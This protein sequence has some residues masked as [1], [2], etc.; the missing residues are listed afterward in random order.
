MSVRVTIKNQGMLDL[1][2]RLADLHGMSIHLGWQGQEGGAIHP[3]ASVP[4]AQ[5]G[6]FNEF[7][8]INAPAR[9]ALRTS[10]VDNADKFA[11]LYA[12]EYGKVIAGKKSAVEASS[13]IGKEMAKTVRKRI[14]QANAWAVPNAPA[15]VE[16][17]G[18]GR[19]LRDSEVMLNAVTWE[20]RKAGSVL[21]RGK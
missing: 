21:A 16:K 7:G 17:K 10:L 19:V 15:T 11:K 18:H 8:T 2:K 14:E 9:P 12:V 1:K 3:M 5:V 4:V 20:V 13:A 6:A